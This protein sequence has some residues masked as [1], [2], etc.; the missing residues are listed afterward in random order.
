MRKLNIPVHV[1]DPDGVLV[2]LMPGAALPA[3][4]YETITNP[5]VWTGDTDSEPD[6]E[7]LETGTDVDGEL[8]EGLD[9][10]PDESPDSDNAGPVSAPPKS[11][12]GSGRD[13]WSAYAAALG[14]EVEDGMGR[15]DLIAA[16]ELA[17]HPTE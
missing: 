4:A 7:G 5:D 3:W 1:H 6:S 10:E 2:T 17:G 8:G 14:L 12:K 16:V 13:A 9:T 11:G 15:D